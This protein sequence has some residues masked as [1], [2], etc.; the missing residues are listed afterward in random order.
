MADVSS[1]APDGQYSGTMVPFASDTRVPGTRT[2]LD[3]AGEVGK[4]EAQPVQTNF[5][6]HLTGPTGIFDPQLQCQFT[7]TV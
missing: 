6:E 2:L 5:M 7:M 4:L 1:G 3:G